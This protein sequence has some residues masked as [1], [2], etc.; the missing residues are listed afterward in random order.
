MKGLM[1]EMSAQDRQARGEV[2]SGS[3]SA[4]AVEAQSWHDWYGAGVIRLSMPDVYDFLYRPEKHARMVH[5]VIECLTTGGGPFVLI[6]HSQ[7]SM[8]AYE[9]LLKLNGKIRV[10]LFVTIGSPL[11]FSL[12]RA[13]FR[14]WHELERL[15]V[16]MGV[17]RW[18][19]V[20]DRLD[21]VAFKPSLAEH[22][23]PNPQTGVGIE[24][25]RHRNTDPQEPHSATGYLRIPKVRQAVQSAVATDLFQRVSPFT[26][27][28]DLNR[29]LIDAP[30]LRHPVLIE[31]LH[32]GDSPASMKSPSLDETRERVVTWLLKVARRKKGEIDVLDHYV[33]ANLTQEQVERLSADLGKL[34]GSQAPAIRHIFRNSLKQSL[35]SKRAARVNLPAEDFPQIS[36]P[37][38]EAIHATTAH[39]GYRAT[40]KDVIW[41]VLDTGIDPTHPHFHSRRSTV[42][43]SFDC[44]NTGKLVEMASTKNHDATGH[45]THVAGLIAGALPQYGITSAAPDARLVSYKVLGDDGT[46]R[47]AW[48]IKAIDHIHEQNRRARSL[49]IHGVNLS[50]GGPFDPESFNCGDTPLCASLL[51]LVRQGVCV[52]IA[53]GNEGHARVASGFGDL[54]VYLPVS[55]NDPANLEEGIAVGST[56]ATKPQFYGP[57]YFSSRGPTADGRLKPDVVAPGE[58]IL[59]CRAG[60]SGNTPES[61]YVT[62][63]GTSMAAPLVSGL[64]AAFL[65]ARPEYKGRPREVKELLMSQC[66]DLK[67]DAFVQGKGTPNLVKMLLST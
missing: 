18:L 8:V 13:K 34:F 4:A 58:K 25:L 60:W 19:N 43:Q 2:F 6:A 61:L 40:G 63:S 46:G 33:A 12:I 22:Y 62:L 14:E 66:L 11:G 10:P 55:I 47:D 54:G 52:V 41:A 28:R 9:A 59:S 53:A 56:H 37:W 20:A 49:V 7:G 48:I 38:L 64:L 5:S 45:G 26:I 65:S 57:S 50:L 31:L 27:A 16:P 51:R 3:L 32:A 29:D 15:S 30:S 44:T 67:R 21:P 39:H 24:D 42:S 23:Q 17:E 36:Q 1:K 35:T